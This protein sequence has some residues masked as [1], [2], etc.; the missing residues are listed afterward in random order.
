MGGLDMSDKFAVRIRKR[1]AVICERRTRKGFTLVE[2]LIAVTLVLLMMT[3]FAQIFQMAG[4]SISKQR[5]LA[6]NDQR[7]RTL[8]TIIKADLDK[9]SFRWVYPFAANEDVSTPQSNIGK[10]QGYFYISENNPYSGIDDV[11]QFTVVT[12]IKDRN[13]DE[14]PYYGQA[15]N[16]ANFNY[17]NQP[18]ADDAQLT[19][20]NTGLSTVA[21][22]VYFV[23]R[24][25]LYR[26]QL[27]IREPLSS[28]GSN[29]QPTDS[30]FNNPNGKDVFDPDSSASFH[31][32]TTGPF[33]NDFDYSAFFQ[34]NSGGNP[35]AHFLGSDS[36]DNNATPFSIV[37]PS[38]IAA[39][40]RRFGHFHVAGTGLAGRPKEYSDNSASGAFIG[41]FTLQ[42]CSDFDFR[43]PQNTTTAGNAPTHPTLTLALDPND[44]TV[45]GP[46]DF[47]QG[48]R[49]GEDLLLPNVHSFDVQVWDTAVPVIDPAT[50][51]TK[52]YGAFVNIGDPNLP[53]TADFSMSKRLN[54]SYGPWLPANESWPTMANACFD[55]WH[56]TVD[57]D[58]AAG[59]DNPPFLPFKRSTLPTWTDTTSYAAGTEV[60]PQV[61]T[62]GYPFFY[63]CIKPSTTN[64]AG[65]SPPNWP[66]V[67][68]LTAIDGNGAKWQAVDNRKPL[69]AIKLE[70]R[71][72][73]P[74]TQQMRQLTIIQSLAD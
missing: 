24:G 46:D 63:R 34:L 60:F 42:E 5:G 44:L 14:T 19:V 53:T 26:R 55:T 47:S 33:W 30:T 23:R 35:S 70:I 16:L 4:S 65:A 58:G 28:A 68:G 52:S 9:R 72:I 59:N 18:D 38:A 22:V 7:S 40:Y 20:N 71:F 48:Q 2:M 27:L 69:K 45:V 17:P 37:P 56:P 51:Q 6:E 32:S 3:M 43:Y 1:R 50:G 25:N 67:A 13:K 31:Y 11:L 8:Q 21:E 61:V 74:S 54:N 29:P 62:L 39:P 10:R 36:L 66:L 57:I 12:T 15:L 41:R 73:D 49:R 64:N